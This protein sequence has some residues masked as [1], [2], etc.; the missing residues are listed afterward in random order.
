MKT[1]LTERPIGNEKHAR[2]TGGKLELKKGK[3]MRTAEDMHEQK[4][5]SRETVHI[6]KAIIKTR[7]KARYSRFARYYTPLLAP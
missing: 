3:H 6:M 2:T 5:K 1:Q 4:K 7:L